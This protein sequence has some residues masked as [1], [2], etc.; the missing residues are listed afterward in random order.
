MKLHQSEPT[1]AAAVNPSDKR[2]AGRKEE[3]MGRREGAEE[4]RGGE[5]VLERRRR[6][7]I[8]GKT[9]K[10]MGDREEK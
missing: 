1:A 10:V 3:D 4:D 2:R 5:G 6:C 8:R 7:K 9:H